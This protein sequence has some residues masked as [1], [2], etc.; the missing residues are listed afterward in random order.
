L[1]YL[2]NDNVSDTPD[3]NSIFISD[4]TLG[5]MPRSN[6]KK[7]SPNQVAPSAD[8]SIRNL[9][10]KEKSLMISR[11]IASGKKHGINM[12][13]G[14]S[15]PGTG[16]CAFESI[17]QN[18]ND[19]S[20]FQEKYIMSID[21]YRRIWVTDM[22]NRTIDSPFNI[23][24]RQQWLDGWK[25]MLAPGTYERGIFGDLMLPGIAC[26]VRKIL[27]IF[28]TNPNTPHDPIYIVDP[29]NFNVR[30]DTEI[31]ILLAYNMAH[32]ESMEPCTEADIQATVELVKDYQEGRYR[33]GRNNIPSLIS[34]ETLNSDVAAE[35]QPTNR[36]GVNKSRITAKDIKISCDN[37]VKPETYQEDNRSVNSER[38][39]MS[40][41]RRTSS[42]DVANKDEP[43]KRPQK[44]LHKN[45]KPD[46]I[47]IDQ[48]NLKP[49][50]FIN[51]EEID[52]FLDN[53]RYK[54][55]NGDSGKD[56]RQKHT[57]QETSKAEPKKSQQKP[58]AGKKSIFKA[59]ENINLE[60]IDDFLDRER[61][62]ANLYY[63]SVNK[64]S[65]YPIREVDGKMEC[66][67][68]GIAVKNVNIHFQRMLNCGDK[69]DM[70]HFS[71]IFEEYRILK[72]RNRNRIKAQNFISRKKQTEP[73]SFRLKTNAAERK[74][75]AKQRE[76]DPEAFRADT[77]A[78]QRKKK[79]K[80]KKADPEAFRANANAA[81]RK[82]KAKQKDAN[83][84]AFRADTNA[85][86][87]KKKDKHKKADPEAFRAN[88]NAAERK[89]KA[90]QKDA[91]PEAFRADTNAAQRKK[92][93]KHKKA[94][95]EA[96]RAKTNADQRKKVEK[97]NANID[98][99]QRRQNFSRAVLFGPIFICS[100]CSRKLYENGVKK[101]TEELKDKINQRKPYFYRHCI[102]KEEPIEID[103]DGNYE[104]SG[105]Y[106]CGTCKTSM[107]QGKIPSMATIN[108]LQ[109]APIGDN[110]HL[111]ELENN[112]IALNINFQYIFC[113]KKSR[114]A[115]TKKQ[116]ISVPVGVDTVLNTIEQL[117][118]MPRQAGL[119]PVNL[120]RKRVYQNSHKKELID[121]DKIFRTLN[122]LK[123]CQNPYYQF[124]DDIETFKERCK[125]Q[126]FQGHELLFGEEDDE[127]EEEILN[128]D[129][130]N[131][132]E[133]NIDESE[134]RDLAQENTIRRH[135]FDH[136]RN[137]CMTNNYPE[138]F[139]DENGQKTTKEIS[140]APAEGNCPTN[141][142]DEK[143]WDIKSW[144][145]LHPDGRF[146]LH[147]KRKT[148]LTHQQ[149]FCHRILNPDP[150]P[151][152]D[153]NIIQH[154]INFK[155]G[156]PESSILHSLI[157]MLSQ[158]SVDDFIIWF[159]LLSSS[160][161]FVIK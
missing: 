122:Y 35:A 148:K 136:N 2:S 82:K 126:D 77:N 76:E 150:D 41:K 132:D 37:E 27:L 23:Y 134:D 124:F 86:Q 72:A 149:Y 3:L 5:K 4:L 66:P 58:R 128:Q 92:K 160:D 65:E 63:R 152:P 135:Q 84:E 46:P 25:E 81:E 51:L 114:W 129:E 54:Y 20:C 113:L 104:L 130:A 138:I 70:G 144:P 125:E 121:P 123:K 7:L 161:S 14:S 87:R 44:G 99:K 120:K 97:Q 80:K 153:S 38:N 22:A 73:E 142:L 15:N 28:N 85:A 39:R 52:D 101:I 16:D 8:M 112:L 21:W 137:T 83:T 154:N 108:G 143:D 140:F 34:L 118:R 67:F 133:S 36:V 13:H 95:P 88:A 68:C 157:N 49:D 102:P 10:G 115:A 139:A 159:R 141:L 48:N 6:K 93:D 31:P 91:N 155:F 19:R 109:L 33:Y 43:R 127:H 42:R 79:E 24:T 32:Y 1:L 50:E 110:C 96:F 78:A 90:K 117:P 105:N 71:N 89:K 45:E 107:M 94:D 116:M 151:D 60:E 47:D 103:L 30:P 9:L 158:I 53:R 75:K 17:I 18:N 119:V 98:K 111:T 131:N 57:Y 40:L 12:K 59:A 56:A 62:N 145:A 74:K 106:I 26:G 64:S 146:G 156:N 100:C 29:S 55:R 11:A 61:N 69:V 147:Y